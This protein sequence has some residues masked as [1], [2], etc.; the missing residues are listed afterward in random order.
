MK[1][2][3]RVISILM[4]IALVLTSIPLTLMPGSLEAMAAP[5]DNTLVLHRPTAGIYVNEITRVAYESNS[6]RAP[7][8]TH[9]VIVK[10]T[11]SGTPYLTGQYAEIAYAGETPYATQISFTPGVTLD[12]EP[13]I[14]CNNT[15]VTFVS[16]TPAFSNGTY[17]WTVSGGTA[18]VGS[19][20]LFTVSYAYSEMNEISNKT[21]TNTYETQCVSYVE[22]IATPAGIYSSKRTF[23]NFVLGTD[24]KNRSY[25]ATMVLGENTYGSLYNGGTGDGTINV[26]D[27]LGWTKDFGVMKYVEGSSSSKNY[28]VGFS[29]DANRPLSTV[30]I[31]KSVTATLSALNLRIHTVVPTNASNDNEKVTVSI[32]GN[33]IDSGIV[34]TFSADDSDNAPMNDA[35]ASSELGFV[36]STLTIPKITTTDLST[37]LQSYFEGVGPC[38][39]TGTKEYTVSLKYQTP[40]DWTEV[41]L[42]HSVSFRFIT[43]DKGSLR[44]LVEEIY[45][46]DPTSSSINLADGEFK[47][48]N[49]QSWYYS[50]GWENFN[51]A[52][53]AAKTV[54][55]KPNVSQTDI[56]SAYIELQTAYGELQMKKADYTLA[57][58][59]Y[60]QAIAKNQS[61]YTLAS[62]AKLQNILDVYADDYSILYQPAVDKLAMD[63]K[64]A[65]DVLEYTTANYSEFNANL[66]TVNKLM[67]E[68]ITIYGKTADKVYNNWSKLESAL[69]SSGCVYNELEGYTVGTYLDVT[70]QS[71]VDGY[72]MLL[73]NAID[74]LSLTSADYTAATTAENK[75]K[76]LTLS[77]IVDEV[78]EGLTNAYNALVALHNLDLSHQSEI[79]AATAT[80][81]YWLDNVEYKPANT[82]AARAALAKASAIDRTQYSDLTELDKAVNNLKSKLS[83][84]I[85]YQSE[86]DSATRALEAALQNLPEKKANYSEVE[87]AIAEAEA[88]KNNI[89]ETYEST[90]GFTAE[91]FYSNWSEVT[92]AINNVD[93][94][95]VASKQAVVDA[96]AAAIRTALSNLTENKADYSA[97]TVAQQKAAPILENGSSLYTAESLNRLSVAYTAVVKNLEISKQA[98]VDAY[99][100]AI[101]DA[102]SKLEYLPANYNKVDAAKTAA[103]EKITANDAYVAAHPGYSLYTKASLDALNLAVSS[104]D[105]SLDITE[106]TKVDAYA[107]AI[108]NAVSKLEYAPADYTQVENAK[109]KIPSDLSLYT[110]LSVATLNSVVNK[111][112]TT[113]TADKQ[114]TVDGY[115]VSIENAVK[116]LKP[117]NADYTDLKAAIAQ[118]E[119]EIEAGYYTEKTVAELNALIASFDMNLPLSA[120]AT[121]D[122]YVDALAAVAR[123]YVDADYTELT[124]AIESANEKIDTGWYTDESV[125]AVREL[126]RAVEY[127]LPIT[128]QSKVDKYTE[129][130]VKATKNMGK[131]LAN[132]TE[133]QKILDLLDNSDSEIYNNKYKN[134]DEVMAL[135][136]AYRTETVSANMQ[137]TIDEQSKVNS[138]T[139]TLQG[140]LD[141]LEPEDVLNEV[142]EAK[143]GST[144]V[145][146]GGYIYGLTTGMSKA[147]FE[148]NFIT[149]ENVELVY[150]GN[151]GQF[152]GTGTVITVKSKKTGEVID[153]YTILIYGDINGDGMINANDTI[154]LSNYINKYYEFNAAQKKAATIVSRTD[155]AVTDYIALTNVVSQI[156]VINQ[157]TGKV[158]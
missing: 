131:K 67:S 138:M 40:A 49:P 136:E 141:M 123:E 156:S 154:L 75:Y 128:Q 96:Y 117:K 44:T 56:D 143:E 46:T 91:T 84:D 134:F 114:S 16:D 78:A 145:I 64:A 98:Q 59:Y 53:I 58:A 86:I 28:N 52:Y 73:R 8:D 121:V 70:Q 118:V 12:A 150:S 88:I 19:T 22:S 112:D 13:K 5:A 157:Q 119:S 81:N 132:Y 92:K 37:S 2:K 103:N 80:L 7:D 65:M 68:S 23:Q 31:D 51:N 97:V 126:I 36:K 147:L 99:A 82:T 14:T 10:A 130:I 57:D 148:S 149:F 6:M 105:T 127:G 60:K 45:G 24:T 72:T 66:S 93:Y 158:S 100:A 120:Q 34:K 83:L 29:A 50:A 144:T 109:K 3:R 32:A 42:G 107:T 102:Y 18:K 87:K 74:S 48:Y 90:Y 110:T 111:I 35:T 63:I 55:A 106:Q 39:S 135:I 116:N 115:A 41:Y 61:D 15:S 26:G 1:L 21:Y 89:L 76:A 122:G 33:Y 38:K 125:D 151:V 20:L 129:D 30:Y 142:F 25:V 152:I 69:K 140:Y 11:K 104:V 43:Y 27:S 155:A 17:T 71:T 95:V 153:T 85:R 139:A 4:V 108:N 79:D 113:L 137:L 94:N 124:K 47:G 62:W 101:E 146:S 9:S 133:L 77:N 54:L